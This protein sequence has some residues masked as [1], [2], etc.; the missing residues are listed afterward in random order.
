M[1][2]IAPSILSADFARLGEAI[3]EVEQAGADCIHA[4]VM[5]G[6]FV[7]NLSMGPEVVA[8][9]RRVTALPIEA[10]LMIEAPERMIGGFAQ[11]GASRLIVH[12]EAS[13]HLHRVLE[14]IRHRGLAAGVALNPGTPASAISEVLDLVDLVLAMTVNPGFAGQ[15]FIAG[16]LPKVRQVRQMLADRGLQAQVEVDGGI[17]PVTAPLAAAAG[18]TTFVAATAVFQA[19]VSIAE[20]M[21]R[22]RASLAKAERPA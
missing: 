15:K 1:Y 21:D 16:V 22:L 19:G 14:E 4:D 5:D 11:A 3:A 10:H 2:R 17:D 12:V 7:P 13:P 9:V 6:H 20:A 8:G 18:A